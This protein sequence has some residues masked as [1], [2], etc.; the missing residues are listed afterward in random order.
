MYP[1]HSTADGSTTDATIFVNASNTVS[2]TLTFSC[3]GMPATTICAFLPTSITLVPGSGYVTPLYTDMTLW[4]DIQSSSASNAPSI[5]KGKNNVTLAMI[6]GWPL[7]L[8][9]LFGLIRFRRSRR[10]LSAL[11]LLALVLVLSG[12]SLVFTG[13]AGP[14]LYK[15]VL[16]PAGTYPITV[17]VTGDGITASTLVNFKVT[18]PGI[19]GQQ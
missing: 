1:T 11:S 18:S 10:T 12:S 16:T 13:C 6:F 17:T 5:G 14:G 7:T 19:V 4:T 2:G 15:P 3:S 8:A 9:G